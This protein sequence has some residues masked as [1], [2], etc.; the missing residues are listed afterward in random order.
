MTKYSSVQVFFIFFIKKRA[1]ASPLLNFVHL[2]SANAL[3]AS[4]IGTK[5]ESDKAH[6]DIENASQQLSKG[7]KRLAT[8]EGDGDINDSGPDLIEPEPSKKP[9][10]A[11]AEPTDEKNNKCL[12]ED[13][14]TTLS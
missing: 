7:I 10:L 2:F 1:L 8:K 4:I 6:G 13:Y 12:D 5:Y 3:V 11:Q 9:K 14:Q